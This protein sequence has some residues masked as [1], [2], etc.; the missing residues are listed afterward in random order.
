MKLSGGEFPSK[1]DCCLFQLMFSIWWGVDNRAEHSFKLH[2]SLFTMKEVEI[3]CVAEYSSMTRVTI[4]SRY[5]SFSSLQKGNSKHTDFPTG[6]YIFAPCGISLVC[7]LHGI[8]SSA[9]FSRN[10]TRK[11]IICDSTQD[12]VLNKLDSHQITFTHSFLSIIFQL[13]RGM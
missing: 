6:R 8:R 5:K 10:L 3:M 12:W 11:D 7:F 9:H 1:R 2:C 13:A 4:L